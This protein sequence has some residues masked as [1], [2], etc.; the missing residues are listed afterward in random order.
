MYNYY[1]APLATN[2]LSPTIIN[3]H[4]TEANLHRF[5]A[6]MILLLCLLSMIFINASTAMA[7]ATTPPVT[8]PVK[9]HPGHYYS[10]LDHGK[11]ASWYLSQVYREIQRT[12]AMRGVH[13]RYSWA[14]LETSEGVYNF[15]VIAKR[16]SEL[17]AINKRLIIMLELRTFNSTEK[18]V[19]D[20]LRT[21]KYD[22]GIFF[23]QS[24]NND[25]QG[26]NIK[27]WNPYVRDRFIALIKALGNR[28]NS[29]AYFEGIGL[30]ET[31]MGQPV[32]P[33]SST[34]IDNY[35]ANLLVLQQQ[36]RIAFPNTVTFQFTNYP[37]PILESFIEGLSTMGAGLGGPDTFL[38]EPGLH[39]P[40]D[41][42]GVYHYYPQLSGIVPL[43]PSIM[44]GNY[45]NTK[46]DGTGYKP[47]VA[48][49]LAYA[50]DNLKANY[51]FWTRDPDYLSKVLE[52]LNMQA[53]KSTPSGGLDATC[54]SAFSS[55]VN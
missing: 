46:T 26:K 43:T 22:G 45:E 39:Y 34:Q 11:N 19:P 5:H 49:L 35:Y 3:N 40:K 23:Y 9:W 10:L 38:E 20:Y 51:L 54:P 24:L 2:T 12:P 18:L 7:Q 33:L 36:M 31:A 21:S 4:T 1:Q 8:T 27:L 44:H 30:T 28:F 42:K 55:C 17:S 16:L 50:R 6:S 32:E 13:I 25:H 37:R 14:E 47:T 48:E 52:L 15:S 29:N 53:Q 41:P